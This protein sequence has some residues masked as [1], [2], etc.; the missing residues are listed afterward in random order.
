MAL[1]FFVNTLMDPAPKLFDICRGADASL[2]EVKRLMEQFYPF[3]VASKDFKLNLV[4]HS[5][6]KQTTRG[7]GLILWTAFNDEKWRFMFNHPGYTDESNRQVWEALGY[8]NA[9]ESVKRIPT[10]AGDPDLNSVRHEIHLHYAPAWLVKVYIHR[11]DEIGDNV[12]PILS[13]HG[14]TVI[15]ERYPEEAK[16]LVRKNALCSTPK[17]SRIL[18]AI[19][20]SEKLRYL[21][22][23]QVWYLEHA[24]QVFSQWMQP[25]D[26]SFRKRLICA[27][28]QTNKEL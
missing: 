24:N 4:L 1:H 27:L 2:E 14:L 8:I 28:K 7:A 19:W 12:R 21:L 13:Q 3:A 5:A 10:Q 23:D 6:A 22:Q 20:R 9:D 25:S 26:L 16:N 17:A 15:L 18:G 11:L